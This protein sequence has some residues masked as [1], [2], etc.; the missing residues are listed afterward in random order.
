MKLTIIDI[1]NN[2]RAYLTML[3]ICIYEVLINTI[4]IYLDLFPKNSH[5]HLSHILMKCMTE[6]YCDKPCYDITVVATSVT[7]D[8][9][10]DQA[11]SRTVLGYFEHVLWQHLIPLDYL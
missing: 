8:S 5:K 6:M 10:E 1:H 2:I 4:W 9:D 3:K 7:K 11:V